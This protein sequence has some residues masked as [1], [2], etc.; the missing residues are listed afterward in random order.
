MSSESGAILPLKDGQAKHME[1]TGS[2]LIMA[3]DL[4]R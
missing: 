1:L 3:Q 4:Q 2:S